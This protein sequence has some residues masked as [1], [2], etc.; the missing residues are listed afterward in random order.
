[1]NFMKTLVS[2]MFTIEQCRIN[3]DTL[4]IFGDNTLRSGEGGQA[5][6]RNQRNAIGIATKHNPGVD[7]K[8]FFR[9]D[10]FEDNCKIIDEDIERV[11]NYAKEKGMKQYCFP[12]NGL[13]TGRAMLHV[14]APKTFFYLC[15]RLLEEFNFNNVEALQSKPF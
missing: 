3:F 10:K 4:F 7:E 2:R 8:D 6:I 12:L 13:G 11:K 9:D 1:M 5:Y 15:N 14:K